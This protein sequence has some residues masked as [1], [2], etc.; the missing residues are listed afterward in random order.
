VVDAKIEVHDALGVLL[1]IATDIEAGEPSVVEDL[2]SL[3]IVP[4]SESI[5]FREAL[6]RDRP[7]LKA[8]IVPPDPN[9]GPF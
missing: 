8:K 2:E 5:D 3:E 1:Q 7:K 9:R 6:K 4:P